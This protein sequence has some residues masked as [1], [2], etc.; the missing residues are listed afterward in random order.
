VTATPSAATVALG[1]R[2]VDLETDTGGVL[3]IVDLRSLE[4]VNQLWFHKELQPPEWEHDVLRALI[5]LNFETPT[6][7]TAV[8]PPHD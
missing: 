8:G 7:H 5:V 1:V 3:A 2:N 6:V 4:R